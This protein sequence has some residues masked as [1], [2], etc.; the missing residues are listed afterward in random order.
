MTFAISSSRAK[1][2]TQKWIAFA[3][4][5]ILSGVFLFPL[6]WMLSTA[7]K[8]VEE[9]VLQPPTWLPAHIRWQNFPDAFAYG[10][11]QLGYI[12][13]LVYG[14]NTIVL[15]ILTV[16]GSVFSNAI[17]AYGFARLRWR[18]RQFAFALTLA[19]F[20]CFRIS[21][22]SP[23]SSPAMTSSTFRKTS[24]ISWIITPIK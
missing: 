6:L 16:S 21:S 4:L 12:P 15:C 2:K 19:S 11:K 10:S 9:T 1:K 20:K 3:V 24:L 13:F 17:I 5:I 14:H 7:L 8:P 22:S 18:G 23:G